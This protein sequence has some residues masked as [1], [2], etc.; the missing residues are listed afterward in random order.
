VGF[1]SQLATDVG[2]RYSRPIKPE[3]GP[4][5][6]GRFSFGTQLQGG[7]RYTDAFN[8]R[9]GPSLTK[10]VENYSALIYAMVARNRNAVSRIPMRLLADGSRV[11]GK[12][13]RACDPIK[14]SRSVGRDL[15][16]QGKVSTAAI[17]QIYEIRNHPLLDVLDDPDPYGTFTREKLI[18]LMVSYMDV[19]GSAFLVPEGNGWDWQDVTA[20]PTGPPE[21]LWVVYPQYVIPVRLAT[22]PIVSRFQYFGSTLPY[23]SVVWF[24]H[25]HSLRDAYGSAFSPTYAGESYRQQEQELVA[26]L[27][28]V[29]GIGPRPNLIATSKDPLMQV[30]RDQRDAF[31][32]DMVRT[33]AGGSAGGILVNDGSWEFT[34][35]DYPKAD[36]AAKEISE[37]DMYVLACIFDQPPTYYT[38]DSNLA[39]LQAADKQHWTQ[40]VEPRCKTIA[41]QFTRLARMFDRRLM[42]AHDIG[43]AEDEVAKQTVIDMQLKS[44][45]LTI[46]EVNE[47]GKIAPKPYGDEPW[48][49]G[50]LVQP[51]MA[52]EKH[53]LGLEQGKKAMESQGTQDEIAVGSHELAQDGQKHQQEMDKKQLQ[54]DAQKK[55]ERILETLDAIT[56]GMAEELE[57]IK[58]RRAG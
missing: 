52:M 41:G 20:R 11:Q 6:P 13:S 1:L 57:M 38:V 44:G 12:P 54:Q 49:P 51:S 43:L 28:Q 55:E 36:I 45:Q 34:Q 23:E 10:L 37:H 3:D 17:D 24:R 48:I 2:K 9:V 26:I 39:N 35:V 58:R 56:R 53:E 5:P 16:Q 8:A 33:Q 30:S 40:G 7:P 18:G 19:I 47:E 50:T 25:N 46:N 15:A 14:V 27:S 32:R 4:Q 42:F 21:N 29:L 22:S 31:G